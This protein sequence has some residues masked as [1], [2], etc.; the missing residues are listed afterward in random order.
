MQVDSLERISQYTS[1]PP[2]NYILG[3]GI[4]CFD[5]AIDLHSI[6]SLKSEHLASNDNL[7]HITFSIT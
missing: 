1:L 4:D 3:H 7:L 5:T 6:A 2:T